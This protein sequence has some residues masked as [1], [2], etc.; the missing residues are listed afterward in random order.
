V[1]KVVWLPPILSALLLLEV[2]AASA[3][4]FPGATRASVSERPVAFTTIAQAM[5]LEGAGRFDEASAAY[6]Q[7]VKQLNPLIMA[8]LGE[9]AAK[10]VRDRM[11]YSLVKLALLERGKVDPQTYLSYAYGVEKRYIGFEVVRADEL[12][13]EGQY[14]DAFQIYQV[15]TNRAEDG[16]KAGLPRLVSQA[17]D[18]AAAGRYASAKTYLVSATKQ[19]SES[20]YAPVLFLLGQVKRALKDDAGAREAF[21]AALADPHVELNRSGEWGGLYG[22][23]ICAARALSASQMSP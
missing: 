11:A 15:F 9:P 4:L 12:F 8:D 23:Q 20:G 7:A 22:A 10:A 17:M 3:Q 18:A 1:S 2:A 5:T 19:R 6:T 16:K 14:A 13:A 21:W